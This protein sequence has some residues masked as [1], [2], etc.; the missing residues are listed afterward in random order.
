MRVVFLYRQNSESSRRFE[1]YMKDFE[2]FHP[3]NS[4]E[5][6]S[7]DSPEGV[8]FASTYGISTHPTIIALKDD[9]QMLY[10]WEGLDSLPL[11]NDL[12]YYVNS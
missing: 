8:H 2:K 3:N 5:V 6:I 4:S 11:M 10:M 7:Y 12:A 9:G 1:E